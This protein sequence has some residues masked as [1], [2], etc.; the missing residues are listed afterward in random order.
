MN[1]TRA[2]FFRTLGVIRYG[3]NLDDFTERA[4]L[5]EE[6]R[7]WESQF[8]DTEEE[9]G[10]LW[11]TSFHMSSWPGEEKSCVRSMLYGLMNIPEPDPISPMSRGIF[12]MGHALE[13]LTVYHWARAG[14]TISGSC[15]V[16]DGAK[17]VQTKFVV[18]DMWVTGSMDAVLDLRP[19]W[20]HALPVDVKGKDHHV[21]DQMKTGARSYDYEHYYQIQS[22]IHWCRVF[23]EEMGWAD[24][25]LKPAKGGIV[26]YASRQKPRHAQEFYFD[27][28]PAFSMRAVAQ[29]NYAK[30]LYLQGKLPPRDKSWRWTEAPCDWCAFKKHACKPDVKDDVVD[31]KESNAVAF[32]K[33]VNPAYE[34]EAAR[35]AVLDRWYPQQEKEEAA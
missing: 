32:A 25:G 4:Y 9:R 2:D 33:S 16:Y 24:L 1:I 26:Y 17:M 18:P 15:P 31:L 35:A 12:H 29:I 6:K 23:H 11:H 22:Y 19:D 10:G 21:I 5:Q 14:L 27:Y 30:E 34:Y 7:L 13:Y 8:D 20:E 3:P 28:D